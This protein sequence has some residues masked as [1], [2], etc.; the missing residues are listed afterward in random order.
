MING[1]KFVVVE[2]DA[3]RR[4]R[5]L[6]CGTAAPVTCAE[7]MA[8][9]IRSADGGVQ[10]SPFAKA[11]PAPPNPFALRPTGCDEACPNAV[12]TPPQ[13]TEGGVIFSIGK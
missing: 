9:A 6:K 2:I 12:G 11:R 10:P 13:V 5:D 3:S 1:G 7:A 8:N 4:G